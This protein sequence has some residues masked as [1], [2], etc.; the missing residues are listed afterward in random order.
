MVNWDYTQRATTYD[1]RPDYAKTA[2]FELI[3]KAQ[4]S[5]GDPVAD[6]GAGTG[7][8]TRLLLERGLRVHAVEPNDNMRAYGIKNTKESN[9]TWT[10]GTGEETGLDSQSVKAVFFGS[11]FNVV[12]QKATLEEC[13][14]ILKTGGTFACMWN[15]RDLDD[16]LQKAVEETIKNMVPNYS[17]GKRRQD[18]SAVIDECGQFEPVE[19]IEK[20]FSCVVDKDDWIDA[21]RSHETLARQAGNDFDRVVAAIEEL[22]KDKTQLSVPY[23]TRIWTTRLR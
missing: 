16:P 4:L 5:A 15:H 22:V 12:D 17:Y 23:S 2:V 11:S 18:P 7:K 20:S 1:K 13:A 6:I 21:W 3:D 14:R 9:V 8:L 10:V 19:A